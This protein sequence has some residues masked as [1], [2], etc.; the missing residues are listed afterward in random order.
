[1][2]KSSL[3]T[4]FAEGYYRDSSRPPTIAAT[5][6][7]KTIPTSHGVSTKVQIWDTAGSPA[8]RAASSSFVEGSDAVIICYDVSNRESLA[9][10]KVRLDE[11]LLHRR[12]RRRNR[13]QQQ[14][15]QCGGGGR[16]QQRGSG[17]M[18]GCGDVVVAIAGLKADLMSASSSYSNA[19]PTTPT[20]SSLSSPPPPSPTRRTQRQRQNTTFVAEY[21][22]ERLAETLGVL[23]FP[24]SAKTGQNVHELFTS[25]ADRVLQSRLEENNDDVD[26]AQH[27]LS[28]V[29]NIDGIGGGS[30]YC[31]PY[32]EVASPR[33]RDKFDKYYVNETSTDENDDDGS[34]KRN[35]GVTTMG[36]D[37]ETM[38][39][40]IGAG[41]R[42]SPT[43]KSLDKIMITE[44]PDSESSRGD[45]VETKGGRESTPERRMN[46][47]KRKEMAKKNRQRK[48]K[49]NDGD[50]SSSSS[51]D[52]EDERARDKG[53]AVEGE[54]CGGV[55]FCAADEPFACQSVACGAG[56]DEGTSCV[57]Q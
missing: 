25:V 30:S 53:K 46:K 31:Q 21:E 39:M 28:A 35:G 41:G 13:E 24:T 44:M 10:M 43:K 7:S 57:V 48:M 23:Y 49:Q 2:G 26:L 33:D 5:F 6:V 27:P 1:M 12:R 16:K 29:D 19:S 14:Q 32:G 15:H 9:S 8:F 38:T 45:N 54:D 11:I 22:V 20:A 37:S 34:E 55:G 56:G 52:E 4:R 36:K 51:E 50:E 40:S 17:G 47:K 3:V 18:C 42:L